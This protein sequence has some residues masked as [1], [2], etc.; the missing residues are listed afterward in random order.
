MPLGSQTNE[1]VV[2]RHARS[3]HTLRIMATSR[4]L[5]ASMCESS[6]MNGHSFVTVPGT[7]QALGSGE[8]R[9]PGDPAQ[10]LQ[11]A[12][13]LDAELAECGVRGYFRD[14]RA[15]EVGLGRRST[16]EKVEP[17]KRRPLPKPR[18]RH[19]AGDGCEGMRVVGE[20]ADQRV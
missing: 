1:S 12:E 10:F 18:L 4:R 9:S 14:H 20:R 7:L 11:H 16:G 8:I 13:L 3:P 5:L 2:A 15:V 17:A 19:Q 6:A